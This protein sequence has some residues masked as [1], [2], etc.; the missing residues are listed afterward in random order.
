[1][2]YFTN[3][4][5]FRWIVLLLFVINIT[6]LV[7]LA[8]K[9][10]NPPKPPLPPPPHHR[11][12]MGSEFPDLNKFINDEMNFSDEQKKKFN[13]IRMNYFESSKPMMD[14]I[15]ESKL[16]IIDE[17]SKDNPDKNL[18]NAES[19]NVGKL[20]TE[21]EKLNADFFISVYALGDEAQ[22]KTLQMFL[23]NLNIQKPPDNIKPPPPVF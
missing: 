23:K 22:K 20:Q 19:E 21:V 9:G 14:K 2:D 18:I 11:G 8:L 13:E 12:P 7:T 15:R 5:I 10:L 3:N 17:L 1:M 16:K 6:A 4:K